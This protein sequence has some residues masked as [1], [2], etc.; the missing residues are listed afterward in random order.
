MSNFYK[1]LDV[2]SYEY[3]HLIVVVMDVTN[4]FTKK[5]VKNTFSKFP[6]LNEK[7]MMTDDI[8]HRFRCIYVLLLSDVQIQLF[9]GKKV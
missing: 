8:L 2:V 1:I 3:D 9:A 5:F 7:N 6:F 4:V